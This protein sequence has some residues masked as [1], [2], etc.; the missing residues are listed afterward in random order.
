MYSC[1]NRLMAAL[2]IGLIFFLWINVNDVSS[3]IYMWTDENGVKRFTN[4]PLK[5]KDKVAGQSIQTMDEIESLKVVGKPQGTS[6]LDRIM[7]DFEGGNLSEWWT[8]T[9]LVRMELRHSGGNPG[10]FIYATQQKNLRTYVWIANNQKDY[11]GNYLAS[12]SRKICID[13]LFISGQFNEMWLRLRYRDS[14]YNGWHYPLPGQFKSDKWQSFCVEIGSYT[15]ADAK[16]RGWVQEPRSASF[17]DTL[18]SVYNI[19]IRATGCGRIE[20]GIDN[21]RRE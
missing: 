18:N 6:R 4:K 10:G 13:L 1:R 3:E 9:D 17:V 5:G 20:L 12:G 11:V 7:D 19:D 16:A 8:N 21:F 14:R 15:D 2:M